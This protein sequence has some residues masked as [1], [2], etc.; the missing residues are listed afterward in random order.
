MIN[1]YVALDLEM[2]GLNPKYD[3]ILEIG[4]VKVVDGR[5]TDTFNSIVNARVKLTEHVTEI[6]G[7][8]REMME[9]GMDM[10]Y[11]V[12]ELID[13]CEDYILLG[14]NIQLDYGFVKKNA[15]NMGYTFEKKGIDTLKI[16]R[17]FLSHLDSRS[18]EYLTKYYKL[19]HENAHRAYSDALA[20]KELYEI[21]VRDYYETNSSAFEPFL[22]KYEVKREVPATMAQKK[23]LKAL[24]QYH[25]IELDCSADELTKSEASRLTDKIILKYGRIIK[26]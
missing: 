3:K 21:L 20:A 24:A 26:A 4:A 7:I 25:N 22:L 17:K 6:T 1:S 23:Y 12:K 15:V 14:H 8:T 18:L 5:I 19:E 2:T 10:S 13:F 16:A 11:A 9:A